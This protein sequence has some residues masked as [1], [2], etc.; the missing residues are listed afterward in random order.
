MIEVTRDQ[1]VCGNQKLDE[2]LLVSNGALA[3]VVVSIEGAPPVT[4]PPRDVI[5]ANEQCRFVPR[6][7]A[8]QAGSSLV[9][10]NR[11]PIL[12]NTHA[13][14]S[15]QSTFFNA[16]FAFKGAQI[17]RPLTKPEL[18][19]FECDAGHTWMKAFVHVF[20]HPFFAVSDASGKFRIN[21]L[22]PG[23]YTIKA[24]H[25][26]LGTQ[27]REIQVVHGVNRADVR[28]SQQEDE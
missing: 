9:V 4:T 11:D 2:S 17:K 15:D 25:E 24:W 23:R 5:V 28:F 18:M 1:S 20:A 6:V 22:P 12:H 7:S 13:Y 10:Q 27:T 16:G 14:L 8:A 26:R 3:N 21:G 19:R